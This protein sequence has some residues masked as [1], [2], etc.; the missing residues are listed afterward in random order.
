VEVGAEVEL[1]SDRLQVD[2]E[3]EVEVDTF[4]NRLLTEWKGDMKVEVETLQRLKSPSTICF[5]IQSTSGP[6]PLT[7]RCLKII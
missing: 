1:F 2:V 3:V 6:A 7:L 4:S 5:S